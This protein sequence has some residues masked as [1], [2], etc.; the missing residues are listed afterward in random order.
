L[1]KF[2]EV[3]LVALDT[4]GFGVPSHL[5]DINSVRATEMFLRHII[6][7]ISDVILFVTEKYNQ[8][9]QEQITDLI[10]HMRKL[11]K[12]V[13]SKNRILIVHNLMKIKDKK[14]T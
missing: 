4:A 8:A 3:D 9:C 6:L 2:F 10:R 11:N 13:D 7:Q 14:N 1:K 5:G 12:P